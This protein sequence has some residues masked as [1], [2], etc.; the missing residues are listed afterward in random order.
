MIVYTGFV[1]PIPLISES[2]ARLL[3][4]YY[5]AEDEWLAVKRGI[6]N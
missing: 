3:R 4:M 1:V 5:R 6:L 2:A